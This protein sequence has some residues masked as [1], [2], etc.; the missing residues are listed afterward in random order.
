[1]MNLYD[2]GAHMIAYQVNDSEMSWAY[3]SHPRTSLL[4]MLIS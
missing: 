2:D 4:T 3:V 1:M